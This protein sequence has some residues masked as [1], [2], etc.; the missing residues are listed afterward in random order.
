V[1][2]A[3]SRLIVEQ[4]IVD[5]IVDW[6]RR[7]CQQVRPGATWHGTTDFSPIVSQRQA[8]RVHDLV[9]RSVSAG[10]HALIGANRLD[11]G[12]PGKFY[13]P[14]ILQ[15]VRADMPAVREEIFGPVM[16][17]QTFRDEEEAYALANDTV[18]GLTAGV[19]T[20]SV[21]RAL[22]AVRRIEA[23]SIWVNRYG[24]SG[25]FVLPTGGFKGSGIGKDLGVEAFQANL[26][27]KVALIDF[28]GP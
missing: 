4:S 17:V 7:L 26:R 20:G 18:Y 21:D 5:E 12:L 8:D 15:G 9:Q 27:Q 19:H 25:D 11:C 2:N 6:I 14:T 1:C 22:R 24:R 16:T 23:G 13:A 3:G 10:A 28:G